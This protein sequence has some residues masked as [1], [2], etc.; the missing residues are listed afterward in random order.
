MSQANK[1]FGIVLNV[2]NTSLGTPAYS[3]IAGLT[4]LTYPVR[5]A[6]KPTESTSHDSPVDTSGNVPEEMIPTGVVSWTPCTGEFN[7]IVTANA[8]ADPG[9]EFLWASLNTTQKFKVVKPGVTAPVFFNAIVEEV[10]PDPVP[11][12][13]LLKHKFKLQP[14]GVPPTS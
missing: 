1:S 6:A 5:A 2:W 13:G 3:P 14:T 9:Q 8:D 4:T 10:N 7:E 11:V 12:K